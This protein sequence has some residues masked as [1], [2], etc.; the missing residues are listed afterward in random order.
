MKVYHHIEALPELN[1][2]VFT[3]GTFDGVHLGHVS[4]LNELVHQ[5][6]MIGGESVL[7]TFWPHPKFM[8]FPDDNQL[9]LLQSLEEKLEA[10]EQI[11]IDHVLVLPFTQAFSAQLPLDYIKEFLVNALNMHTIIVGY[12]HRFGKHR[13]GD[14]HMLRQYASAF[15]YKVIEVSARDVDQIAVSSTKIRNALNAGQIELANDY[16]GR[17]YSF[18]ATVVR[19]KQLGRTIGYPTANLE[20]PFKQKL[21]PA[22]GVYAVRVYLNGQ[23]LNGMM[24]IGDNPTIQDKPFSIEVHLFDFSTDIYDQTLKVEMLAWLRSEKKFSG[25]D[26]LA[27]NL[28]FDETHAREKLSGI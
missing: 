15:N 25:L 24:N 9:K 4:L 3:Q 12:D 23:L 14:I 11:G 28:K 19:G 1:Q 5:A 27:R 2:T 7:L 17:P 10:F 20:L 16:L 26:E 8:L 21:I 6:K 22:K 13:E 18:S